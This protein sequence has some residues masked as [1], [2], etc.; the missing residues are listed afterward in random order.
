MAAVDLK[1]LFGKL[2]G[3]CRQAMENAVGLAVSRC[4]YE[5]GPEHWLL[6]L[7]EPADTDLAV[8][9]R[10]F[11][12][13]TARL[14][15]DLTR[16][17]ERFRTGSGRDTASLAPPLVQLVKAAW[18]VASV[19]FGAARARSGHVLYALLA[20]EAADGEAWR[21]GELGRI[22]PDALRQALPAL[23]A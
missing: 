12:L 14:G 10:H 23:L 16:R 3:T 13:D 6:K 7:L 17:L 19:D 18:L 9:A 5:V 1:S 4:H 20:E 2:N 21:A 15:R 8:I 22:P 11:D